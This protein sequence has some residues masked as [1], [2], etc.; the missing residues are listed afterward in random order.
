M[1]VY[2]FRLEAYVSTER[3]VVADTH[4][5]CVALCVTAL[6]ERITEVTNVCYEAHLVSE[7]VSDTWLETDSPLVTVI[8]NTAVM[9][10]CVRETTINKESEITSVSEL[11]ANV[12]IDSESIA[13]YIVVDAAESVKVCATFIVVTVRVCVRKTNGQSNVEFV[14]DAV[15][16]LWEKVE[17]SCCALLVTID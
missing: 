11:V 12:R 9:N 3:D 4:V 16:N 6:V 14:V 5:E 2:I 8:V 15:T 13:V 7:A 17:A 10:H 1:S